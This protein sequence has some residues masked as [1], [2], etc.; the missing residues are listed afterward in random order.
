MKVAVR[1]H[2]RGGNTKKVA[3]AIARAAGAEARPVSEPLAEGVDILFFGTAPY[4]FDVDDEAK[5]FIRG[6]GVPVGR[7]VL[8]STSAMVKSIR[9]YVEKP[10]ADKKIPIAGEEFSCRGEFAMLHRGRPSADD[11]GEAEAFARRVVSG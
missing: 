2:S 5:D 10:F 7:V 4:G 6:I 1:Y 11:L 3:E 9:K 8:F